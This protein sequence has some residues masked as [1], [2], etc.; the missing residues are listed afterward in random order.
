[1]HKSKITLVGQDSNAALTTTRKQPTA[2]GS[3]IEAMNSL[4]R[5]KCEPPRLYETVTGAPLDFYNEFTEYLWN[6]IGISYARNSAISMER[7]GRVFSEF[8]YETGA[9]SGRLDPVT[10]SKTIHLFSSYLID[11]ANARDPIVRQAFIR[12][13]RKTIS[14]KSAGQFIAAANL[15]LTVCSVITFEQA[16]MTSALTGLPPRCHQ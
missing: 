4:T 1:M 2:P 5:V 14:A 10:A 11:G 7:G 3:S 9:L 15:M 16:E 12:T 6:E 8:L 13:G